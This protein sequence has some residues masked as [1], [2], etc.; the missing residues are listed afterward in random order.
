LVVTIPEVNYETAEKDWI[1]ELQAG[2]KLKVVTENKEMIIS[3]ANIKN[4]SPDP[5]NINSKLINQDSSLLLMVSMELGKDK[6]I[7]K[8]NGENEQFNDEIVKNESDQ[9]N[10]KGK[11]TQQ[12]GVVQKYEVK[13]K[14][15]KGY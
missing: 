11:I 5:V 15:V 4:I 13:L 10:M 7:E 2:T 14:T 3:G 1:K 6:Y 8:A 12:Q 9:E